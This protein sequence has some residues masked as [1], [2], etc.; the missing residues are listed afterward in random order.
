VDKG[1][2]SRENEVGRGGRQEEGVSERETQ[3]KEGGGKRRGGRHREWEVV[4]AAILVEGLLSF[5][6]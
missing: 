5:G 1:E 6:N 4:E 2:R 3:S